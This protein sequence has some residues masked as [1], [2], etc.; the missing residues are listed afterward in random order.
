VNPTLQKTVLPLFLLIGV[1]SATAFGLHR[2]VRRTHLRRMAW[3]PMFRP[4]RESLL[5]QNEEVDRL[6]LPRIQDG[7]ELEQVASSK[8]DCEPALQRKRRESLPTALRGAPSPVRF[9][10][11]CCA[12]E[13]RLFPF[14]LNAEQL[15]AITLF[16]A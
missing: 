8:P 7:D 13:S 16:E 5:R 4:S 1:L 2:Y 3:N 6:D 10:G 15:A 12:H 11:E 9:E 14:L